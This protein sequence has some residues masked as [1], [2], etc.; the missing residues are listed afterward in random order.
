[1]LEVNG[2]AA[3]TTG[4]WATISDGRLKEDIRPLENSLELITKLQGVSFKWS[5]SLYGK[6]LQR[7]FVAQDVES[8]LPAWVSTG[9]DG[10]MRLEKIGVEAL[11]VEAIKEQQAQI[12]ALNALVLALKKQLDDSM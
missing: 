10:N 5:D 3:N 12:E 4:V 7:G 11:L 9:P 1:M 8:V 2:N 6:S